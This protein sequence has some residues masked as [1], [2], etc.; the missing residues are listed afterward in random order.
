MS[1][2]KTTDLL[3]AIGNDIAD[4]VKANPNNCYVYAEA[5]DGMV[6]AGVF[7]DLGNSIIYYDPDDDLLDDIQELWYSMEMINKW[8]GLHYDIQGGS[9]NARFDYA[10]SSDREETSTDRRERALKDR[11]GDKP[12]IYP[13]PGPEFYGVTEADFP[14]V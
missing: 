3:N 4:I 11:F 10:D 7:Q 13:E 6:E 2:E 5:A 1:D 8:E 12:I 9:F 14:R